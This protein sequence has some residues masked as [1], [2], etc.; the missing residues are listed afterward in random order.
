MLRSSTCSARCIGKSSD[1][2]EAAPLLGSKARSAISGTTARNRARRPS[3]GNVGS[4][5]RAARRCPKAG[6]TSRP[7]SERSTSSSTFARSWRGGGLRRTRGGAARSPLKA[8]TLRV[9]L[10]IFR[11]A[12]GLL[13]REGA[14]PKNPARGIG[15]IL[16]ARGPRWRERDGGSR[17]LDARR[18]G[19]PRPTR[20]R[21]RVPLRAASRAPLRDGPAP[22]RGARHSVA[23]RRPRLPRP[24]R[25]P[26]GH[27]GGRH[28]T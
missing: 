8:A 3:S 27:E 4:G 6:P 24:H 2:S 11:R 12:L 7:G 21:T 5:R 1:V 14:I 10:A 18:G 13:E 17:A 9:H 16:R 23:R 15:E 28:D 19:D 22:G 25:A 20:A 26:R